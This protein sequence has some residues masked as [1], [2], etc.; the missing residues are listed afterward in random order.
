[1]LRDCPHS[2]FC[3]S[4][5][6]IITVAG[7]GHPCKIFIFGIQTFFSGSQLLSR[8]PD[9]FLDIFFSGSQLLSRDPNFFHGIPT[10]IS[11]FFSRDPDFYLEIPTF[12][13]IFFSRDPDFF[14][15][16]FSGLAPPQRLQGH[17][18]NTE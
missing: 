9:F 13:S 17:S 16:I 11:I 2:L 4:F 1:M 3:M 15:D 6:G 5:D 12:I 8:D 14:L 10:F 18:E 7:R